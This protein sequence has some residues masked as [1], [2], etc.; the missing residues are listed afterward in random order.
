MLAMKS[1]IFSEGDVTWNYFFKKDNYFFA[2][3]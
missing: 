3:W 2:D 1:S